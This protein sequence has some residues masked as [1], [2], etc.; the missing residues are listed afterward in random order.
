MDIL[1]LLHQFLKQYS[2]WV[3]LILSS[4]LFTIPHVPVMI[5]FELFIPYFIY[6][7]FLGLVY[8][9][10]HSVSLCIISHFIMNLVSYL[11]IF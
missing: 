10:T 8:Y 1:G 7:L 11:P 3:A 6:G 2:L 9:K 4:F 5:H